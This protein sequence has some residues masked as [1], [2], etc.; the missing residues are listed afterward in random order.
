MNRLSSLQSRVRAGVSLAVLAAA[1]FAACSPGLQAADTKTENKTAKAEKKKLTGG[2]LYQIHCSR[3]HSERYAT[4]WTAP[5]WK[6]IMMQMQIRANIPPS[7]AKAIL[8]Y[9][10]EDSGN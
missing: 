3:C 8:K 2:E 4:E 10:Q 9:L 5:Q 7:Q 1:L 6:S